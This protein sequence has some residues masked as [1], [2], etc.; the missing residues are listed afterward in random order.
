MLLKN[1]NELPIK[2]NKIKSI[3]VIG[4][5][6]AEAQLGIYSGSPNF[7]VSPLEGIKNKA[8]A[9]GIKVEYEIGSVISD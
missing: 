8:A 7:S 5:N 1:D 6:A 9:L 3:A 2:K 4:P